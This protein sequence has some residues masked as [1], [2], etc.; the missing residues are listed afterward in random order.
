V[1]ISLPDL[2]C[3]FLVSVSP[4]A[5]VL[6]ARSLAW[7]PRFGILADPAGQ[8]TLRSARFG[9]LAARVCAGFD[10]DALVDVVDWL[11]WLFSFDDRYCERAGA[12]AGPAALT[13][14]LVG[15]L[16]ML[17]LPGVSDQ[18]RSDLQS[19]QLALADVWRRTAARATP[20]QVQRLV[21][22]VHG[23]FLSLVWEASHT[24]RTVD[25]AQYR[26]M[27]PLTAGVPLW[28][29]LVEIMGGFRPSSDALAQPGMVRLHRCIAHVINWM[30]DIRSYPRESRRQPD[31]LSLPRIIAVQQ[32][33]AEERALAVAASMYADEVQRYLAAER[34]V[35]AAADGSLRGYVLS[36]R[37]VISGFHAWF[38]D[39]GRYQ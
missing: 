7:A 2:A 34:A 26:L 32:G 4:Y 15:F 18:Y 27:R 30:N 39:S 12:Q 11:V 35:L 36:L 16:R 20:G 31:A 21:G 29:M 17:D 24:A 33:V 9:A 37:D 3:P 28:L 5:G 25:L 23:Y 14:S 6:E 10:R 8:Q 1:G 19:D 13:A 22:A 38:H